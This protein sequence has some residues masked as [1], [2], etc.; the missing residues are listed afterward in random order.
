MADVNLPYED[1]EGVYCSNPIN[2]D[3][4]KMT[5]MTDGFL[6][7][8]FGK[9]VWI[10]RFYMG[11]RQFLIVDEQYLY[12]WAVTKDGRTSEARKVE[13]HWKLF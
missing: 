7:Y 12:V 13:L 4:S 10:K 6:E 3:D 8:D 1:I 5:L 9:K 2:I 11:S